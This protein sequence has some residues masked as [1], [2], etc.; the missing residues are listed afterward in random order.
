MNLLI[1]IDFKIDSFCASQAKKKNKLLRGFNR[2]VEPIYINQVRDPVE[3]I[4]SYYH[5]NRIYGSKTRAYRKIPAKKRL[6]KISEDFIECFK[7]RE[8]ECSYIMGNVQQTQNGILSIPY[9]CGHENYCRVHG[10]VAAL[11]KAK[12]VIETQYTVVGLLEEFNKTLVVLESF[13]PK[14]FR[15][16]VN[17]YKKKAVKKN[18]IR[19]KQDFAE[20]K[21]KLKKNLTIEYELY[22]FIKQILLNQYNF[23]MKN[24]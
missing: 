2:T 21:K 10:N 20:I 9:F 3:R 22:G 16:I 4:I 17:F 23:I 13:L 24:N 7:K 14:Y 11:Q 12:S 15:G 6:E 19:R 5:Y 8:E 18:A 1:K